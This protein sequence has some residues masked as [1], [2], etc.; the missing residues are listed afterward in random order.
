VLLR[1]GGVVGV[2][3]EFGVGAAARMWGGLG[4]GA[5]VGCGGGVEGG[6]GCGGG[7]K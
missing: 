6:G 1:G 7:M 4:G 5:G 2:G 3:R